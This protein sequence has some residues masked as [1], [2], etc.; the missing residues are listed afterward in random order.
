MKQ[1]V[2][3]HWSNAVVISIL[4][5]LAFL[6][7]E[8]FEE[9]KKADT[10]C[11]SITEINRDMIHT[12]DNRVKVIETTVPFIRDSIDQNTKATRDMAKDVQ[13]IKLLLKSSIKSHERRGM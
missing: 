11:A 9:F 2:E 3:R 13:E 4:G 10:S 12:L 5:L 7:S 1:L 6:A 8:K